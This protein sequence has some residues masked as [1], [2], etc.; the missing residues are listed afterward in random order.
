MPHRTAAVIGGSSGIGLV[1]AAILSRRG[2]TVH[3]VGRDQARLEAAAAAHPDLVV[4]RADAANRSEIAQA[5]EEI[6]TI[7]WLI[8]AASG[9]EGAGALVD[10]DLAVLRRAFEG[11]FWP[12]VTSIQSALPHLAPDGSVTLVG[13]ISAR[14]GIPGSAGLASVNGAVESLVKPLAVELGPIRVNAVS[15]GIVDTPWWD[16]VPGDQREAYFEQAAR[17]LPV[18]RIASAD[19]VAECVAIAATNPN[20]TGTVIECDGGARLATPA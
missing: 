6:G 9:A 2:A 19:D 16:G 20:L 11:K 10:L 3:I 15:P 7:D 12:Y 5:F 1:T 14:T 17:T 18:G 4:H 8:V 13:A